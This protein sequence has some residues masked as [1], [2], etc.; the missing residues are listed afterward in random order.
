M[1]INYKLYYTE[2]KFVKKQT[3]WSMSRFSGFIKTNMSD[4]QKG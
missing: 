4:K 3:H 2:I 1:P